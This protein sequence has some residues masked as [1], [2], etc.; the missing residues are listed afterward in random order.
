MNVL[1]EIL[2]EEQSWRVPH[3]P[4]PHL[5]SPI[6]PC[7]RELFVGYVEDKAKPTPGYIKAQVRKL[8]DVVKNYPSLHTDTENLYGA[9]LSES[10]CPS[11]Q[12]TLPQ[13]YLH[14]LGE[15][16]SDVRDLVQGLTTSEQAPGHGLTFDQLLRPLNGY[17]PHEL[18][19]SAHIARTKWNKLRRAMARFRIHPLPRPGFL[20]YT[21]CGREWKF[22]YT[23]SVV[24]IIID[25]ESYV[26]DYDQVL[27]V[28]DTLTS[29]YLA[30]LYADLC[31]QGYPLQC[32]DPLLLSR[33]Y[34]WGDELLEQYG[35]C[36][37]R[38]IKMWEPLILGLLL[39]TTD[40]L[41]YSH[42][43][44]ATME[45]AYHQEYENVTRDRCLGACSWCQVRNLIRQEPWPNISEL[46]GIYRHWGHPTVDL[47]GGTV[48]VQSIAKEK[49]SL[50]TYTRLAIGAQFTRY[51]ILSYI[52][53]HG[54]WP[55]CRIDSSHESKALY[56]AWREHRVDMSDYE[57]N[58]AI[59]D[60]NII[61]FEKNFEFDYFED[62]S[63]LLE[64]TAISYDR[65]H[66]DCT[67][68]RTLLGY[69]PPPS[70][71]LKRGILQALSTNVI[72][73]ESICRRIR[74]RDV[75]HKWKIITVHAKER[76][77]K[78]EPRL[79]AMMV[80]EMRLYYCALE[81]NLAEKILEY[82]PQQTMTLGE[83]DL[84]QRLLTLTSRSPPGSLF[85]PAYVCVDFEK[86][87]L[88]WR[89]EAILMIARRCDELFGTPG[90]VTYAHEFFS[91]VMLIVGHRDIIPPGVT[92]TNRQHPPESEYIWYD[93]L[94]GL[95][96]I[97]QKLWTLG[98]ICMLLELSRRTGHR[99]IITGQ[100]DNQV[101]K[102]F[103]PKL[104][105]SMSDSQYVSK[106][107]AELTNQIKHVI[108]HLTII[109]TELGLPI[110]ASETWV[111]SKVFIYSKDIIVDGAYAPTAL[112]RVS[113][114]YFDVA[115]LFPTL[116][117]KLATIHT[118]GQTAAQKGDH[119]VIS[120][121]ISLLESRIALYA[122]FNE[123]TE[124]GT[125]LGK[126]LQIR[127]RQYLLEWI[128]F[129]SLLPRSVG[130]YPV[131]SFLSYLYR[132]HPD[133]LTGDLNS[134]RLLG[135]KND[136][137]RRALA[138]ILA[139]LP[140]DDDPDLTMLLQ[141]PVAVNWKLPVLTSNVVKNTLQ[142][143][144]KDYAKNIDVKA[145]FHAHWESEDQ[146]I[147]ETL[148]KADPFAVR[149]LND[150]YMKSPAGA[151]VGFLAMFNNMRT[152][153][154]TIASTQQRTMIAGIQRS[155]ARWVQHLDRVYQAILKFPPL[156][157]R[158]CLSEEAQS[159]RQ[160]SWK[161]EIVG[162]TVPHPV[163]QFL[164]GI[165]EYGEPCSSGYALIRYSPP[166]D[167]SVPWYHRGPHAAY[168]GSRTQEKRVG[169]VIPV[170]RSTPALAAARRLTAI[171]SWA[172]SSDPVSQS[173][174]TSL[175]RCRTNMPQEVLLASSGYVYSGSIT[176]RYHDPMTSHDVLINSR[177]NLASHVYLSSDT[178]GE[179][180]RGVRDL[181]M[182]F[183]GM[184]L[185]MMAYLHLYLLGELNASGD[186]C[187]HAHIRC[188]TCIQETNDTP[189]SL[190]K[191]EINYHQYE[192]C[193]LIHTNAL[194]SILPD[195]W[196]TSVLLEQ[197]I[198]KDVSLT[199]LG[200]M[201][202]GYVLHLDRRKSLATAYRGRQE[203]A[204]SPGTRGL[205]ILEFLSLG[206]RTIIKGL[207][208]YTILVNAETY[209]T[210]VGKSHLNRANAV[211]AIVFG[212]PHSFWGSIRSHILLPEARVDLLDD[213]PT[214]AP[215]S[216]TLKGGHQI[217]LTLCRLLSNE[218]LGRL[219]DLEES[220]GNPFLD[221]LF[222][223]TDEIDY[224]QLHRLWANSWLLWLSTRVTTHTEL[225]RARRDL[226][227]RSRDGKQ[228][229]KDLVLWY[230]R[231]IKPV[232]Q[233][234]VTTIPT[235]KFT[236][237]PP[238]VV[239]RRCRDMYHPSAH[240]ESRF[241]NN[242]LSIREDPEQCPDI[243]GTYARALTCV[244]PLE[245]TSIPLPIPDSSNRL[246]SPP[247]QVHDK[248]D[249]YFRLHGVYSTAAYKYAEIVIQEHIA[250]ADVVVCLAE[251]SGGVMRYLV[252]KYSPNTIY[253][254]TLI[255]TSDFAA[256]RLP[257]Y[258]PVEL[259]RINYTQIPGLMTT[260]ETGGDLTSESVVRR[261]FSELPSAIDL[262]TCD[263]EISGD[264]TPSVGGK[265]IKHVL[266]L[267]NKMNPTGTLIYKT[268]CRFP[269]LLTY[270]VSLAM[271]HF[272]KVK[273]VV[274][275]YSCHKS[276]E[277]FIVAT[278]KNEVMRTMSDE[279][280]CPLSSCLIAEIIEL[281][282]HRLNPV[283]FQ[284]HSRRRTMYLQ[285]HIS[286][287]FESN[288]SSSM[289]LYFGP[290]FA[291]SQELSPEVMINHLGLL[292]T[293][294][295]DYFKA[296]GSIL[297]GVKLQQPG[298]EMINAYTA[299][300]V[301]IESLMSHWLN[302]RLMIMIFNLTEV[303]PELVTG[304]L[305]RRHTF[306]CGSSRVWTTNT[307]IKDWVMGYSRA[308]FHILGHCNIKFTPITRG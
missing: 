80:L 238:E 133:P 116:E 60:W 236:K 95:E 217:D 93:H 225:L 247:T 203:L 32:P 66:W 72:N 8:E 237:T 126:N 69:N 112:K 35:N 273:L 30:L 156:E 134:L 82:F 10:C 9:A 52:R 159:L 100:G 264:P 153:Q 184:F 256:H 65:D 44:Y 147:V 248:G 34:E 263:A 78:V 185:L 294:M 275:T 165:K 277:I 47:K 111:S 1:E 177:P 298:R 175:I 122:S 48:K 211:Q 280:N 15:T 45:D 189:V 182:H 241:L 88:Q 250:E 186:V 121:L 258:V 127:T 67:Y 99:C 246:D 61:E 132:G 140:F 212:N 253:F 98:T 176:H 260:I 50:S 135:I 13:S 259:L 178:L 286:R 303:G 210:R 158:V 229:A 181:T 235:I 27:L 292:E 302:T 227:R 90:L 143:S 73:I 200:S 299:D 155:E 14:F 63:Q 249:H 243:P 168:L 172:V 270:E 49:K 16:I 41:E 101:I 131:A 150:I 216:E 58:I 71:T 223:Q 161:K 245:M 26:M 139:E 164:I 144:V 38:L 145:L 304:Y 170:E 114:A 40:P 288:L 2:L 28:A 7:T 138:Y 149:V 174:L 199:T 94:G 251:G 43:F 76:E 197:V 233:S 83:I 215:S 5:K 70:P 42:R 23:S 20:V 188:P 22:Y 105:S 287:Y 220:E 62:W 191:A 119:P 59:L 81:K 109:A 219:H 85:I 282:Q 102:V 87:N 53:R 57:D 130:G 265:L 146:K 107:N 252:N 31:N 254:N 137:F 117:S 151:R 18:I 51:L 11:M 206:I 261:I 221:L 279:R 202:A 213:L 244:C 183:Q 295:G 75:P 307:S 284:T 192:A 281:C 152:T 214:L 224:L 68:D 3:L 25:Q 46:H 36:A 19:V 195:V 4:D 96:G 39:Q 77:M 308:F 266:W 187:L 118:A 179:Y 169:Q 6:L 142:N 84:T 267:A 193:H 291:P 283:P 278:E 180:A 160:L 257:G 129:V 290:T 55:K 136:I 209:L 296:Y 163:E 269:M 54:K 194:T 124:F 86:W 268:F 125:R 196:P 276:S 21:I 262:L 113:R 239:L 92:S 171:S 218:I 106:Y 289:F 33:C 240:V 157:T 231:H 301:P 162:V 12:Q 29:R 24:L 148:I 272:G 198:D 89:L 242:L 234:Q 207:A 305:L 204:V 190:P 226:P 173:T 64:D 17:T 205:D 201:A 271:S 293:M 255:S 37:Y 115:E 56:Q 120:Y 154:A 141:D 222:F 167:G 166:D 108:T 103:L 128:H 297:A 74:Q 230:I 274:P 232:R 300:R 228:L 285:N 306:R 123:P 79:F 208:A 104:D 110:K 91:K 97:C